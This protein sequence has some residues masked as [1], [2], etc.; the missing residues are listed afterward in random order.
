MQ[1]DKAVHEEKM[2]QVPSTDATHSS[3]HAEDGV[4]DNHPTAM[5]QRPRPVLLYITVDKCCSDKKK[6]LLAFLDFVM[7]FE[8]V[9]LPR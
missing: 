8:E 6:I 4:E 1:S 7:N 3:A 9:W 5:I 2:V